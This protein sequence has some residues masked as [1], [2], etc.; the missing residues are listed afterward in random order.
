MLSMACLLL[1]I[2]L[3]LMKKTRSRLGDGG[4][5]DLIFMCGIATV[6][7]G[8]LLG[9]WLGDLPKRLFGLDT[10]I[11]FDPPWRTRLHS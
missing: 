7:V 2:A 10:A 4:F 11:L 8:A 6:F 9:G 1:G 5:L 3:L